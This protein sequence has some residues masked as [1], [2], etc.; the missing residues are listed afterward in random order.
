MMIVMEPVHI[1]GE[2]MAAL[3]DER[4]YHRSLTIR[5]SPGPCIVCGAPDST[6]TDHNGYSGARAEWLHRTPA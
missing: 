3:W 1:V 2:D 4:G 5:Y 6:C